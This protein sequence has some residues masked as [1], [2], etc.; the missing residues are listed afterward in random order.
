MQ[1]LSARQGQTEQ[2]EQ[3]EISRNHVQT[4][5][6]GSVQ[7]PEPKGSSNTPW[8]ADDEDGQT[9]KVEMR[10]PK[11]KRERERGVVLRPSLSPSLSLLSL[12]LSL[13]FT[14]V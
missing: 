4:F 11:N 12:S 6:P 13:P 2:E 14:R 10:G 7:G 8:A 5:I 3:E 1:I 9:E